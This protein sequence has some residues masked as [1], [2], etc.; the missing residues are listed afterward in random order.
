[1]NSKKEEKYSLEYL[2]ELLCGYQYYTKEQ[3]YYTYHHLN[4]N[5]EEAEYYLKLCEEQNK[6]IVETYNKLNNKE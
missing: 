3:I 2:M 1:M 5:K 4:G 6:P